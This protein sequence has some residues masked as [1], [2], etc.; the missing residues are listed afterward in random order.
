MQVLLDTNVLVDIFAHRP[1][2]EASQRVLEW[3][4]APRRAAWIS[5]PT[6]ATFAYLLESDG[7]DPA[8]VR[9]KIG[10]LRRWAW[11]HPG[12]TA[13]LDAALGYG[14]ADFEDAL[15]AAFAREC[16]ATLIVTRNVVDF[17]DS[18]VPALAPEDFLSRYASPGI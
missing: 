18:P 17:A 3:C 9:A 4:Q 14:F 16:G 11:I 15:Q 2:W 5:W 8:T 7:D 12:T 13:A 10:S 1:G 6:V